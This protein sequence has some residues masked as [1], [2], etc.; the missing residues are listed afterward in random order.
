M[1]MHDGGYWL[2]GVFAIFVVLALGC[3]SSSFKALMAP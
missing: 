3:C 1:C 2:I